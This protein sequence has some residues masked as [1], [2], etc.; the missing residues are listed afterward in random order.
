M[1]RIVGYDSFGFPKRGCIGL[2]VTRENGC[3]LSAKK[4]KSL[5]PCCVSVC[6]VVTG[7]AWRPKYRFFRLQ[8]ETPPPQKFEIFKTWEDI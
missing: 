5:P 1:A 7:V 2:M 4:I 3:E 8:V 6:N